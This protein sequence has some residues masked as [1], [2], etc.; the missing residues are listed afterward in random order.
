[1]G[2]EQGFAASGQILPIHFGLP[3][4]DAC[5]FPFSI[6]HFP[7]YE[8]GMFHKFSSR[9]KI[10]LGVIL[11]ATFATLL[12]QNY[13]AGRHYQVSLGLSIEDSICNINSTFNCDN[14][15]TSIYSE[16]WGIPM[17]I[18]GLSTNFYFLV[19]VLLACFSRN[20]RL[21]FPFVAGLSL[22]IA[23]TSIVMG[24]VSM[25][26]LGQWCLFCI[27]VYA[28]SFL[29]LLAVW[30]VFGI[31][32][33]ADWRESASQIFSRAVLFPVLIILV[34]LTAYGVHTGKLSTYQ[35]Q[36]KK[37]RQLLQIQAQ[38]QEDKAQQDLLR[39]FI[40]D[41]EKASP[42][43]FNTQ[44]SLVYGSKTAATM[45][46]VEFAD[47]RCSHCRHAS[48]TIKS[49]VDSK[50]DV[51]W[52]FMLYPLDG[53]CNPN[54]NMKS[55]L[56]CKLA[57][58][59]LCARNS[60]Q[61]WPFHEELFAHQHQASSPEKTDALIRDTAQHLNIDTVQLSQCMTNPDTQK[62]IDQQVAQATKNSVS[63]T[64]A[65]FVNGKRL[66]NGQFPP[67]LEDIYQKLQQKVAP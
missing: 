25:T 61:G 59:V 29:S 43:D 54:V 57:K 50:P 44:D 7:V 32:S 56:S 1:M 51:R 18:W 11:L 52:H 23:L 33:L 48:E 12:I 63:G 67:V 55:G 9:Q 49:F 31:P 17:A 45:T 22:F 15:N 10:A 27:T 19:L 21:F 20:G 34:P 5:H 60:P 37:Q 30:F 36:L 6:F 28:L 26:A 62:I 14:V 40:S 38:T 47:M 42:F 4:P 64:P 41:W 8:S 35:E 65:V 16:L 2:F 46:I 66:Q 58:A 13:L 53:E 39:L 24:V 3:L